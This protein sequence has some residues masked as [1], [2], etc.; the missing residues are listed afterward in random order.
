MSI[1]NFRMIFLCSALAAS[2]LSTAMPVLYSMD[3]P[4]EKKAEEKEFLAKQDQVKAESKSLTDA[5]K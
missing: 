1:I 5:S 2:S 4:Q 3:F